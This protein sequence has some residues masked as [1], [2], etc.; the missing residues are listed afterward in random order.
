[1]IWQPALLVHM[2]QLDPVHPTWH[3]QEQVK[4]LKKL[5]PMQSSEL[6]VQLLGSSALASA[7]SSSTMLWLLLLFLDQ[8][9][10]VSPALW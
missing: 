7:K 9:S 3:S 4:S 6:K 5:F 8:V 2:L 10:G 1:M